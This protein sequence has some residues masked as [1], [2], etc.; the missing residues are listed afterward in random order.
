MKSYI[1]M[2]KQLK[3]VKGD[4]SSK[5]R[6]A[7]AD[8]LQM[9]KALKEK[10]AEAIAD[11]KQADYRTLCQDIEY[12]EERAKHEA[13]QA[14]KTGIPAEDFHKAWKA[15]REEYN[16]EYEKIL[17]YYVKLREQMTK[18]YSEILE[19]INEGNHEKDAFVM[20]AH[21]SDSTSPELKMQKDFP[22]YRPNVKRGLSADG[23]LFV[24]T[25]NQPD[26]VSENVSEIE[27]GIYVEGGVFGECTSERLFRTESEAKAKAS[28]G[29]KSRFLYEEN[30]VS[31]YLTRSEIRRRRLAKMTESERKFLENNHG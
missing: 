13:E 11:G 22:E 9:V 17:K 21:I 3:S 6:K 18:A 31:E 23:T 25:S 20:D 29:P 1:E 15:Y 27:R 19:F 10:R 8:A 16:R 5:H 2:S 26:R 28:S 30:G 14:Q 4:D 7:A 24:T 12:H